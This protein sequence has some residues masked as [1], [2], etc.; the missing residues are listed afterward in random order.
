MNGLKSFFLLFLVLAIFRWD[1]STTAVIDQVVGTN[2]YELCDGKYTVIGSVDYPVETISIELEKTKLI[3]CRFVAT[4]VD[5]RNLESSFSNE[6][7]CPDD[8]DCRKKYLAPKKV[9]GVGFGGR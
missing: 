6:F 7:F 1:N 2:I 5:D 3:N 8:V 9:T 4:H